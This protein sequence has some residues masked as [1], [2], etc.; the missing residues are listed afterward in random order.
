MSK[1]TTPETLDTNKLNQFNKPDLIMMASN[2]GS[3]VYKYQVEANR[4][5]NVSM[6]EKVDVTTELKAITT[7]LSEIAKY[8]PFLFEYKCQDASKKLSSLLGH[9]VKAIKEEGLVE[10]ITT[11]GKSNNPQSQQPTN[12]YQPYIIEDRTR[13][14]K[15]DSNTPILGT[16]E[17]LENIRDWLFTIES[18][19]A[20]ANIPAEKKLYSVAPYLRNGP[21]QVYK[22]YM[23][24]HDNHH[25][26]SWEDF[27]RTLLQVCEPS[28][29]QSKLK[30]Q[31]CGIKQTDSFERYVNKFRSIANQIEDL[32]TED[33]I[34]W[35]TNGLLP[36]TKI[37]VLNKEPETLE[38]AIKY[39]TNAEFVNGNQVV[40]I[41][42][43]KVKHDVESSSQSSNSSRS[44][45]PESNKAKFKCFYCN[46]NG[47]IARNCYKRKAIEKSRTAS[48]PVY[49]T[50]ATCLLE[51]ASLLKTIGILNSFEVTFSF[52][53]GA[54]VSILSLRLARKLGIEVLKSNKSIKTATNEVS[55]VIGETSLMKVDI[56]GHCCDLPFIVLDMEDHDVL[57]GLDWFKE[58]GAGIYPPTKVIKD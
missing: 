29:L 58:S 27:K 26:R 51:T 1:T 19:F 39:A 2:L 36:R 25:H 40:E 10:T 42:Y 16:S 28:N 52:D 31:L 22:K 43:H 38:E 20:S 54:V 8:D 34:L 46:R 37:E 14:F 7:K 18:C 45:S 6:S 56:K 17:K 5:I 15:L 12:N 23:T 49:K 11:S 44:P 3:L 13:Q 32:N 33:E 21:F 4:L 48:R 30:L 50:V 9:E 41:N 47:H 53:S 57:L 55:S 35:F 24:N